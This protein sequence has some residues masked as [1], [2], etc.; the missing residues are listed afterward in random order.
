[1]NNSEMIEGIKYVEIESVQPLKM[2][3]RSKLLKASDFKKT[4]VM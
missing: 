2:Y 1:M 4:R 3:V